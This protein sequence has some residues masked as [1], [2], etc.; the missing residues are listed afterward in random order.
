VL[1]FLGGWTRELHVYG[2]VSGVYSSA[3][4]GIK[5]LVAAYK[6]SGSS[7]PDDIWFADWTGKPVLTDPYVRS[8]YWSNHQRL[9]QYSGAHDEK[10]GGATLNID[11]DAADGLVVG[12]SSVPDSAG[13]A[14]SATPSELTAAPGSTA[15]VKLTLH[16]L[17]KTS[18]DVQWQV[19]VP[20][21]MSAAPSSGAVDLTA[22]G[23][24]SATVSLTPAASLAAGRYLVPI[25]VS[26]SS[27]TIAEAYVLA[28]VVRSGG[29]LPT[30]TPLVLYA[31]DKYD[32]AT[33]A[34]IARSLAL[35][36]GNVT[37]KFKQAWKDTAGNKD[38]VIAVGEPAANA[39]YFNACGWTDPLGWPAGSTPFYYPGYPLRS[40]PGRNY[41][42]LA[43]TPTTAGTTQLTTQLTQYALTGTLP[44]YG[45]QP[46]AA[47]PPALSCEGS[48]NVPVR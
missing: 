1:K 32:M 18:I 12:Q 14:E 33:A 2:Y 11:S 41:F 7:R 43:S 37:G 28:T 30:R 22:G 42:E 25:T 19:G 45:S 16:G 48:A 27:H 34:Q 46:V 10:W 38:L 36:A 44:S 35:P 17:P 20:R 9:H 23:S 4:S 3:A 40:P 31:A 39:L 6:S 5:D 15:K 24:Y 21:G 8:T 26:S 13:P 47:T 29:S